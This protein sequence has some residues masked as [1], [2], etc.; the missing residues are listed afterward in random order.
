MLFFFL[1]LGVPWWEPVRLPN[2]VPLATLHLCGPPPP[3]RDLA[4]GRKDVP[5]KD[6][7]RPAILWRRGQSR[8]HATG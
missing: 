1:A 3:P 8:G 5:T 4:H 7:I 2:G 6:G